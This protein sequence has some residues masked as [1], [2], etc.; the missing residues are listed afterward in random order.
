MPET[1]GKL[2]AAAAPRDAAVA[3]ASSVV[4]AAAA[5]GCCSGYAAL[6]ELPPKTLLP[7]AT[8]ARF[9]EKRKNKLFNYIQ[10]GITP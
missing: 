7:S 5:V 10:V 9:L 6:P 3:V 4:I 1:P 8:E 2:A